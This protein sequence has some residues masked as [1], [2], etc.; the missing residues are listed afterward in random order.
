MMTFIS[1]GMSYFVTELSHYNWYVM[2]VCNAN[3]ELLCYS[4]MLL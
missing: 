2:Q 4:V 1:F 3:V